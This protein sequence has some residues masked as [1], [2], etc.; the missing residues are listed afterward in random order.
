[1]ILCKGIPG[2]G[3]TLTAEVYAELIERP[4]YA[5]HSGSL[6]TDAA[7]IE[8]KPE[9]DFLAGTALGLRAVAG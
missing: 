5:V 9:A 2:V 7:T 6:G 4:L 8:K 1:M 3:K